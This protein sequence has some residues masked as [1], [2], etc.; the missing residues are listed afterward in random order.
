MV[1]SGDLWLSPKCGIVILERVVLTVCLGEIQSGGPR[2][3]N[4]KGEGRCTGVR[5]YVV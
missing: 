4:S 5:W 3:N 1:R 2:S